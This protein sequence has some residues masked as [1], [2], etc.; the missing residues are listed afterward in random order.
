MARPQHQA[1]GDIAVKFLVIRTDSL[2]QIVLRDKYGWAVGIEHTGFVR[3]WQYNLLHLFL[4]S[5]IKTF[6]V[7]LFCQ[8]FALNHFCS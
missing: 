4:C 2:Y 7:G 1:L 8:Q 5:C 3:W 6:K